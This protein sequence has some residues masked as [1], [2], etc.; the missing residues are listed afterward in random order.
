MISLRVTYI[1]IETSTINLANKRIYTIYFMSEV[2]CI[3][4]LIRVFQAIMY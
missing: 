3:T 4:K 1:N 2:D